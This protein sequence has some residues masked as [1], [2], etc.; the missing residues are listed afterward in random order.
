ML[1]VTKAVVSSAMVTAAAKAYYGASGL[2]PPQAGL[3]ADPPNYELCT[4]RLSD[5]YAH[6]PRHKKGISNATLAKSCRELYEAAR[7]AGMTS[8]VQAQWLITLDRE[9]GIVAT[10]SEVRR[11]HRR[12]STEEYPSPEALKEFLAPR[13]MTLSELL[14]EDRMDI[15]AKKT[16]AMIERGGPAAYRRVI[17]AG[18]RSSLRI[19]CSPGYVVEHCREYKKRQAATGAPTVPEVVKQVVATIAGGCADTHSCQPNPY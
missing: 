19:T 5:L 12:I 4:R 6:N 1:T 17:E 15:L 13:G 10:D 7:R 11:L 2:N 3:V 14:F 9:L 18:Q 16:V 8:V